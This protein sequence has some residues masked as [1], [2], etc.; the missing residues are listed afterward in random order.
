MG[1]ADGGG[2]REKILPMPEIQASFLHPFYYPPPYEKGATFLRTFFGCILGP[3]SRQPPPANPFSKLHPKPA[4]QNLGIH[5]HGSCGSVGLFDFASKSLSFEW[6]SLTPDQN[7]QGGCG[8][9]LCSLGGSRGPI[10]KVFW[11]IFQH[12]KR[13]DSP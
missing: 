12:H 8:H 4:L 2:W 1:L 6:L 13:L 3:A 7:T 10:Q 9:F 5:E 11:N